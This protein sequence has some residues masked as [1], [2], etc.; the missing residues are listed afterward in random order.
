[1]FAIQID[2]REASSPYFSSY[3]G[4]RVGE[5]PDAL[6]SPDETRLAHRQKR[7]AHAFL[8]AQ[9]AFWGYFCALEFSPRSAWLWQ[10]FLY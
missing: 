10:N 2:S 8:E 7:A 6:V 9:A 5:F 4:G 1:V 3:D